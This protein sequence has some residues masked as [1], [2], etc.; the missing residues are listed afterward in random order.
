MLLWSVTTPTYILL[1]ATRVMGPQL[2]NVDRFFALAIFGIIAIE[3]VADEQQW[4]YQ[5]AKYS[6][7]ENAKVP[8]G[9][10]QR[11]LDLGF[12]TE[13]LWKYSRHP[14]FACEQA[15][16]FSFYQWACAD[17]LVPYNWTVV[18]A[19]SYLALFQGSTWLTEKI[20]AD[21]YSEYV[22]YQ[23]RVGKFVPSLFGEGWD[24]YEQRVEKEGKKGK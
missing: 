3:Y 24:A 9:H 18:G 1:L 11:A 12:N 2:T 7:R 6:Y 13:G 14:N 17:T 15:V 5:G 4:R 16:W 8:S 23:E 21:K 20:T 19:I 10:T 22:S